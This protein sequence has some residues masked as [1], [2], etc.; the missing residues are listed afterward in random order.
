MNSKRIRFEREVINIS[1][2]IW[3]WNESV[4]SV[5]GYELKLII[6]DWDLVYDFKK[7]YSIWFVGPR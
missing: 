4:F 6:K 1:T 7:K 2:K 5:R 3:E